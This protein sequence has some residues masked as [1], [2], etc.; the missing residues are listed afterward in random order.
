MAPLR[1]KDFDKSKNLTRGDFKFESD[2]VIVTLRWS[3]TIQF[4]QRLLSIPLLRTNNAL[5]PCLASAKPFGLTASVPSHGPAFVCDVDATPLTSSLMLRKVKD[6]LK[7]L[8]YNSGEFSG[9]SFRRG[10]ASFAHQSGVPLHT[11]KQ[12][13]DWTSDCYVK[14]IF[15]SISSLSDHCRPMYNAVCDFDNMHVTF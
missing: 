12:I 1:A 11:I 15:D 8:G 4:G 9:H 13:G 7:M 5:C 10:G 2:M 14:Y 3:K 6:I